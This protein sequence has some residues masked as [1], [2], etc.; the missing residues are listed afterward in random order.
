[1]MKKTLL[2]FITTLSFTFT[3]SAQCLMYPVLLS[4]RAPQSSLIIE[5]K[6]IN[7]QSFWNA[8]HDKI[9]TSNLIE[10]YKTFKNTSGAYIEIVTEGGIVG[11]DKHVFEP[12]LELEVGDVGVFTLN[13]TN[14]AAQFGRPVYTA[15]A[16]AQGF[17]KYDV[18]NNKASEPFNT[19]A[20]ASTTLYATL[21]QLTNVAYV[22]VKPINPFQINATGNSVAAVAAITSISPTTI[23]AGTF[24]VLTINGSGFGTVSTPSLVAFKNADDGG[25]T[26][27]SP[28][29]SQIV[30]WSATQIQVQVPTKAG[31]GVV[32]VNGSNSATTLTVP[33]SQLN[34]TNSGFVY[35]TKH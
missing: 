30:S 11:N 35:N 7:Q 23:T 20:N 34:V 12:T 4:Q 33:Y 3:T 26:T 25:A 5:G 9:Y 22:Q 31:T 15:Y 18:L 8:N 24:S 27:I 14:Q 16:N 32:G 13:T 19:Y 2:L 29:A 10:V 17:I 21:A 1:M 28:I 6:V